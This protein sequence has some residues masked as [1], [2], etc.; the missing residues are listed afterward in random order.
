MLV[1]QVATAEAKY[2][3]GLIP[4]RENDSTAKPVIRAARFARAR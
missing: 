1:L 2:F 4:D 3:A